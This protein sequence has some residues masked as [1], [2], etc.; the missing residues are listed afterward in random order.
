MC[1]S[2]GN[3]SLSIFERWGQ[4]VKMEICVAIFLKITKY[5]DCTFHSIFLWS[6]EEQVFF[7][8]SCSSI[9]SSWDSRAKKYVSNVLDITNKPLQLLKFQVLSVPI[10]KALKLFPSF[11]FSPLSYDQLSVH[12]P[13]HDDDGN[14]VEEENDYI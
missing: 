10:K 5:F 14:D 4:I 1:T 2:D 13:E 8:V 12:P 6:G 11:F 3:T 9:S 7:F